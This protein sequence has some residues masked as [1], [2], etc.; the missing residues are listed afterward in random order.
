MDPSP[1]ARPRRADEA[2][3]LAELRGFDVLDSAADADID[4]LTRLAARLCR[5]PVAAV[6]LVD[7]D[8]Q[9][10][11]SRPDIAA[12]VTPRRVSF[13]SHAIEADGVF[14]VPDAT[15]DARFAG[16]PLVAGAPHIVFY[17]GAPLVT[18]AGHAIGALCVI[19]HTPRTLSADEREAL[20][21]IGRQVMRRLE[22]HRA[23][24]ALQA[25]SSERVAH[26]EQLERYASTLALS[27]QRLAMVLAA[28]EAGY[29]DWDL[30][31]GEVIFS[32]RFGELFQLDG[33]GPLPVE[34]LFTALDDP[35]L[36]A[37]HA[38]FADLFGRRVDRLYEEFQ[39]RTPDGEPTWLR[40]RGHVTSWGAHGEP[41]RALGLA[42]DITRERQ[43]DH[44]LRTTQKLDAIGALAAGVAHEINTPLQFV[45]HNL[46]FLAAHCA[47]V[48]AGMNAA[49]WPGD[50]EVLQRHDDV[51]GAI[52]ESIDG[53]ERVTQIVRALKEF[54]HQG[55]D[56]RE[57]LDINRMI[58]NAIT[59]TRHEWKFVADVERDLAPGL[60]PVAAAGYECGQLLVNLIVNAAH[61]VMA[62]EAAGGKGVI[63]VRS[64]LVN[65]QVEI[66]LTDT[67]TGIAPEIRDRIF[68]PFFTTKGVGTGT[69][70]GLATARAIVERHGGAI[71]F[72]TEVGRGTTFIVRFPAANG[73]Q[74]AA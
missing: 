26:L 40:F 42:I 16:T 57:R 24:T 41:L 72:E 59:L 67:G 21:L 14:E 44:Q 2:G 61:A 38:A 8:H 31:T 51:A 39:V 58:E 7:A 56:G 48:T 47:T 6:S 37:L 13:C 17:A 34:A 68:E 4:A 33:D 20:V 29:W 19:D 50:A 64:R 5:V 53:L 18:P 30:V 70:Q 74:Q 65:G 27:E 25:F 15:C 55:R 73:S 9:W 71:E 63:G 43:R 10:F 35:E 62:A 45:S 23:L 60:P 66:R 49:A 46:D 3:R 32:P 12:R 22:Q 28:V 11:L 36:E 54:S 52:A 1:P 69:G